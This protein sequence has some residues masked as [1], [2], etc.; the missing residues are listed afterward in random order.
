MTPV[1]HD[2]II[3]GGG[4]AAL[5]AAMFAAQHG[6]RTIVQT[7]VLVGGQVLNIEHISNYPGVA[8]SIA[9]A[10][11]TALIERQAAAAGA[12][13]IYERAT[14]IEHEGN[15][16]VVI[17][18]SGSRTALTVIVATGSSLR[19]L[20]VPGEDL[21]LGRGV[22]YCGSCDG[23]FFRGQR[24]AVIGGGDSGA[25]EALVLAKSA[26]EVIL[27]TREAVPHAAAMTQE[28]IRA[29]SQ[30]KVMTSCAAIE[31][32][33]GQD[34]VTGL[35][36]LDVNTAQSSDL[37]V[38]GVFVKV[39]LRPNTE[40]IAPLVELASSG[41]VATTADMET[42]LPGLYAI[43]DIRIGNSKYLINAASDGATAGIAAA[44]R[45]ARNLDCRS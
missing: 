42:Q 15:H 6:L 40:L 31:V 5:T 8:G 19:N 35:R 11:L 20:D 29:R 2:V 36:L 22:S 4:V 26:A 45:V 18:D 3:V 25:E 30:I 12:E 23:G 44:G 24:V 41:H 9:G 14:A 21:Y 28:R 37:E 16:F 33:G 34:G 32:L 43:G 7:D 38:A 1:D 39:G 17:S 13:F 27:V 10:E